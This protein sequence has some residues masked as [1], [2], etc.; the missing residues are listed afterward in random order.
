[1]HQARTYLVEQLDWE[2]RLASVLPVAVDYYTRA[3]IG[4]TIRHLAPQEEIVSGGL[5]RAHGEVQVV[6]QA[7]GYRKIKRY[8]HETLGFGEIDLPPVE[9]DTDG[10]WLVFGETL[11]QRLVAAGLL[12]PPNDYGPNWQE[13]RQKALARDN[14]RCRT[15]GATAQPGQGLHVH[16]LRPFREYG[17]VSGRN[18][19]Y[20]R[21]NRLDNLLTLCA[22]C[23][24]RAEEGQRTRSALGGFAYVLRNLAPLFLMCDPA[25][26]QVSAETRNPITRAPT[27]VVYERVPAG[28][29]FSQRLFALHDDLLAAALEL[30]QDCRCRGGCPACVGPPGDIGPDTKVVTRQ[31]LE[32]LCEAQA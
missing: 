26:I 23:H 5:L 18:R 31:L 4:S 1:M 14:H 15:C 28:V 32:I 8:S 2:N 30:V 13:Q 9:L 11:A 12:L 19:N 20:E 21:A 22:S 10:Y 16:H 27:V 3:S 17:Y 24:R 29:G 25:D 7:S 6:T